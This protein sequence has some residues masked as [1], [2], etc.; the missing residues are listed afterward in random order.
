MRD[1]GGDP[2]IGMPNGSDFMTFPFISHAHFEKVYPNISPKYT[3]YI[4]NALRIVLI[5]LDN[6]LP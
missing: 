3:T 1:P 5:N 6:A 4:V 2:A